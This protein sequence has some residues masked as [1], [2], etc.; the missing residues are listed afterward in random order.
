MPSVYLGVDVGTQSVRVLAVTGTGEVAAC[1]SHPLTSVRQGARHEQDPN[2]WWRATAECLREVTSALGAGAKYLGVAVDAT[3]GTILLADKSCQA[4]TQGLMYDDGR[5]IAEAAEANEKGAVLWEQLS[6]RMQAS[7]ALPKLLWLLRN[8]PR[9]AGCRLMHQNDWINAKLAGIAVASDSS[10][11]LKTGYDLLRSAWPVE[12]FDALGIPAA[13]FPQVVSPGTDIGEVSQVAA[14]ETGLPAGTRI[15]AGMTDGCAAQIASGA[16][17]V[18]D[19]N[20]VIGTTLVLKGVTRKLLN[21]PSRVIYSHRSPEGTW[22]PGGASSSG[23]GAIAAEFSIERLAALNECAAKG[24]PSHIV[25]YPLTGRGE[26]FPFVAPNAESFTLGSASSEE[27]RYR[28]V[29]QGIALLE[30]LCFDLL[31]GKGAPMDGRV[32]ISGGAVRSAALNQIRADVLGRPLIVPAVTESG[33]GMAVLVVAA[34][35]SMREAVANMVKQKRV[36]EP[37][38][39][40]CDYVEQYRKL[41]TELERRNWLPASS[42]LETVARSCT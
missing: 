8:Q 7:W 36:I 25:V 19:W 9:V 11:S 22:L 21:D 13:L 18:G 26:R 40:F 23:A 6:Y 15:Y 33:F 42:L 17:C 24:G 1:A 31:S 27:E 37:R 35:S 10:H 39:P 32:T 38:R 2:E 12:I 5:A 14:A 28:A 34:G 16:M 30:R 4:R 41:V 20:S 3:S 29:L